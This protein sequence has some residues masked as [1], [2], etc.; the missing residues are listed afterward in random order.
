M[1]MEILKG[2]DVKDS[3]SELLHVDRLYVYAI[4]TPSS[5]DVSTSTISI[6]KWLLMKIRLEVNLRHISVCRDQIKL[7]YAVCTLGTLDS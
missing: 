7:G 5:S 4:G 3:R 2:K 1:M 6:Y